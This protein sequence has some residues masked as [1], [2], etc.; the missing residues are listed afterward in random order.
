MNIKALLTIL[1]ITAGCGKAYQELNGFPETGE[2][3]VK[4]AFPLAVTEAATIC[5]D[6]SD[7]RVV[8]IA[9]GMLA[10]DIERLTGLRP[11]VTEEL[12]EGSTV[13]AGTVGQSHLIDEMAAKGLISTEV[14][15]GK[16]ESY[17]IQT[18]NIDGRIRLLH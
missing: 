13:I 6:S 18:V 4:G 2:R 16:W 11:A 12:P 14:L 8:S 7:A 15:K 9:G 1:L 10:D 17:L 5:I 3:A